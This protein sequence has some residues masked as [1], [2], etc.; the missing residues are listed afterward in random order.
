MHT[1]CISNSAILSLSIIIMLHC[2]VLVH[3]HIRTSKENGITN[4]ATV[5]E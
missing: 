5:H 3:M 4:E 2:Y 1:G